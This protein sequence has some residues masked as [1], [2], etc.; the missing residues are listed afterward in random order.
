MF[1]VQFIL[2]QSRAGQYKIEVWPIGQQIHLVAIFFLRW[3][4]SHSGHI[5]T[6]V[7]LNSILGLNEATLNDEFSFLLG[8]T[9]NT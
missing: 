3:S 5:A 8:L 6:V 2:S 1:Q 7:M 4:Y 9:R